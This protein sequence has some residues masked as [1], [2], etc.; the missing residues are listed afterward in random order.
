MSTPCH[1]HRTLDSSGLLL[2]D[3]S[4]TS[5][6]LL[7]RG[8]ITSN[9]GVWSIP[10][11]H[12]EPGDPSLYETA[13]RE[14]IEECGSI[15]VMVTEL[16]HENPTDG[17]VTFVS[18][19]EDP[20]SWQPTLNWEHEDCGW[21]DLCDLPAPLHPGVV[22]TLTFA[23]LMPKTDRILA[24][25]RKP[26]QGDKPGANSYA[27]SRVETT[28]SPV[29]PAE[30]FLNALDQEYK[31]SFWNDSWFWK[32]ILPGSVV[33]E[34][35]AD[36]VKP[37]LVELVNIRVK[38]KSRGHGTKALEV[39]TNLADQ[40]GVTLRLYADSIGSSP[41]SQQELKR[42]YRKHGFRTLRGKLMQRRP[43]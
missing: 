26:T 23:G 38:R 35:E 34:L 30:S 4:F 10:G 16:A 36:P 2:L 17:F 42:W 19:C 27:I 9:G 18:V 20:W 25:A 3:P 28:V 40:H 41:L 13:I 1:N 14:T 12:W 22:K 21:F 33:V 15:P 39:L 5:V 8:S 24:M 11:G 29:W 32:G 31:G 6:F 7:L 43:R 37:S